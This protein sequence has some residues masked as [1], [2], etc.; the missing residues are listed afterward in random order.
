M[1]SAITLGLAI[2]IA[3]AMPGLRAQVNPSTP[4]SARSQAFGK[5][6]GEKGDEA[7]C[8]TDCKSGG[9]ACDSRRGTGGRGKR[10]ETGS[11]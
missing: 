6:W 11:S 5:A 7:G 10:T 3:A 4:N 2:L 9:K 8:E 1:R